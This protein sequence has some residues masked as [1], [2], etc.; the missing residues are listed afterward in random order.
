MPILSASR[1]DA[2]QALSDDRV[3]AEVLDG[4]AALTTWLTRI[5]INEALAHARRRGRYRPLEDTGAVPLPGVDATSSLPD[6]ERQAFARE[7]SA[8]LER[9]VDA[10]PD[11]LR[12]VFVL[13]QIQGLS[14]AET[15]ACL[16]VSDDV[17][18]TRLSRARAALRQT[19]YER[20]GLAAGSAF[21]F[22]GP[23][24]DR[25]VGAVLSRIA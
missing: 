12:E 22:L 2:W 11:G 13:R 1:L 15:A 4:R 20:A 3:V 16:Q 19:L 8:L 10:L 17:V 18:K 5:V 23:R 6:P 14:T 24:C 7:L 25:I 21:T 9:A